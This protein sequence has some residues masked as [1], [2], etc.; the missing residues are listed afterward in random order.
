MTTLIV[1]LLV[2]AILVALVGIVGT[3]I[4]SLPGPPLCFVSLLVVYFACPGQVTLGLLLV[5]LVVTIV[6]TVLDYLTPVALTKMGGGSKSAMWGTTI[7]TFAGLL[8]M[9]WGLILGPLIGA[10]VGEMR[11]NKNVGHAIKVALMSFVSFVLST[12][13]KLM[14]SLVMTYYVVQAS[15]NYM[16]TL[17]IDI[18]F[19][20]KI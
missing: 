4:P 17:E 11:N 7:G 3:V 2:V 13:I 20:D 16:R 12:G 14:A 19:I 5:M 10:F 18:P 8:F 15:W 9:P 6:V 1:V